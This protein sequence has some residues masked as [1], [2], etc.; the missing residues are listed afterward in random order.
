MS[1]EDV[2]GPTYRWSRDGVHYP[3]SDDMGE[4]GLQ[5][6]VRKVLMV[7]LETFFRALGRQ[8]LVGSG[9]FCYYR[10]GDPRA[11]VAPDIYVVDDESTPIEEVRS[12]KVWERE[13]RAPS[14]AVEVVSREYRKDYEPELLGAVRGARCPRAVPL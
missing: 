5:T 14:L 1:Q 9:Q 8:V 3:E 7:L 13:G 2:N 4:S 12:W 11:K 10:E 6:K